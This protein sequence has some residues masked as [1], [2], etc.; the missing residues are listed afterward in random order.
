MLNFIWGL[1]VF[2]LALAGLYGVMMAI[3][4]V[5]VS[6]DQSALGMVVLIWAGL[7]VVGSAVHGATSP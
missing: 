3:L 5:L 6:V 1:F 2:A 7:M 4:T